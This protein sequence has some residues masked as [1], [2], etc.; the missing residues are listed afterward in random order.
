MSAEELARQMAEEEAAVAEAMARATALRSPEENKIVQESVAARV[1]EVSD[2][3]GM[4]S[5]NTALTSAVASLAAAA[6]AAAAAT[7]ALALPEKE[8]EADGGVAAA[9]AAAEALRRRAVEGEQFFTG[10]EPRA[11]EGLTGNMP[12]SGEAV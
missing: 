11:G 12:S 1:R 8:E 3:L 7:A 9:M 4:S 6:A 10:R 2:A 5:Q